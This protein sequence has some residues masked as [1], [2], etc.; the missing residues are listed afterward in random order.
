MPTVIVMGAGAAGFSATLELAERGYEVILIEQATIG[1]G[2]S[3]RNPG[4][5][6]HGF[7]YVD[8]ETAKMYLTASIQVQRKYPNY[9]VGKELPPSDPLRRGRYFITKN[10]DN[11]SDQIL[12]T[13][14]KIKEE[15][16]KLIAVDPANKV[17]GEPEDFFRIL[18]PAEYAEQ[19][20]M[21]I[22]EIGIETAEHLFDWEPFVKDIRKKINANDKI[23]LYENTEVVKIERGEVGQPRFSIH[24]KTDRSS[25]VS[26]LVFN[27]DYLV[28]S[29]WQNIEK[30]NDQLGLPMIPGARTNRLKA[31]VVVKLPEPLL[32]VNSM[33]FCMGQHCMFS[34]LGNGFGMV[35]FAN[36]TNMETSCGINVSENTNRLLNGGATDSEINSISTQILNGVSTY[37][38][39]MANA[40]IV[41]V[42]FGIVRTAGALALTDLTDPNHTFHRRDYYGISEEQIG[43]ISNPCTKLFY[44]VRNGIVVANLIKAH[45]EATSLINHC[46]LDI[47][48]QTTDKNIQLN[49]DITKTIIGNLERFTTSSP[50]NVE[51][52]NSVSTTMTDIMVN[53]KAMVSE[54][55]ERIKSISLDFYMRLICSISIK[56]VATLILAIGLT[57][58]IAG[59]A[60][61]CVPIALIGG[62][63]ASVG[64]S[65]FSGNFFSVKKKSNHVFTPKVDNKP[66][67]CIAPS[68]M[69]YT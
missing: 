40:T 35:S 45:I 62:M 46:V 44:F 18:E 65:I 53:K 13:Y 31:L 50:I 11:S 32:R 55:N 30:F 4:R 8:I 67:E 2:S 34:N 69:S 41:D 39:G 10:S 26:N 29:T 48:K 9:I 1:S 51:S 16:I 64:A 17:F 58:L 5:M 14:E 49:T 12:A 6:G 15:Y 19:V 27:T 20:N 37:I 59:A 60:G 36:I 42:K 3:G 54:F 68:I 56:L 43:M 22:V 28:N 38:P 23:T 47:K 7:H 21:D 61:G 52:T 66:D 33:F 63:T 57:T 25:P 24:V